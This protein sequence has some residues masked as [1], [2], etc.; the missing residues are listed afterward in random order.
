MRSSIANIGDDGRNAALRSITRR[1]FSTT[2]RLERRS[3]R[4]YQGYTGG[5]CRATDPVAR[6]QRRRQ[7]ET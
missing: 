6:D 1:E 5:S 3:I 7:L 4:W 2:P